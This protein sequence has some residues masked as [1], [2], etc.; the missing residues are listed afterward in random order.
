MNH[1]LSRSRDTPDP[2]KPGVSDQMTSLV[3]KQFVQPH[4][5]KRIVGLD[6]F[7]YGAPVIERFRCPKQP[8]DLA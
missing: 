7:V 4:R 2:P 5:S 6:I 3:R 1:Q 8:P